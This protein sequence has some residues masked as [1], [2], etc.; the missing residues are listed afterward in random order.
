M[1]WKTVTRKRPV[2]N[3]P[4]EAFEIAAS[5]RTAADKIRQLSAELRSTGAALD[6]IWEGNAK[7]RFMDAYQSQ[8][9]D[10]ESYAAWLDNA[11]RQIEAIRVTTWETFT[12]N[13]WES[14]PALSED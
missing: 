1:A 3:V 9:G 5:F 8:P 12:E 10:L 7:N 14:D 2:S 13:I 11:A 6:S 4:P